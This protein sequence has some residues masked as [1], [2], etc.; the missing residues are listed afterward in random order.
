[1]ALKSTTPGCPCC[2]GGGGGGIVTP[3][4]CSV[5]PSTFNLTWTHYVDPYYDTDLLATTP[6]DATMVYGSTPP[7]LAAAAGGLGNAWWS[8]TTFTGPSVGGNPMYYRVVCAAGVYA[9]SIWTVG[10]DGTDGTV[11]YTWIAT[12]P[13]NT[14][15]PFAMHNGT[16]G[17]VMTAGTVC[18]LDG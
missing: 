13:F 4:C 9:L 14:C 3:G 16:K 8:T 15:S 11:L 17:A 7:G 10:T 2:G 12:A 18:H 6:Y 1:M 5:T